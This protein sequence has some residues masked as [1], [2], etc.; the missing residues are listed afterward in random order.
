MVDSGAFDPEKLKNA[1]EN[2]MK[3]AQGVS[4]TSEMEA[5]IQMPTGVSDRGR[6]YL[7]TAPGKSARSNPWG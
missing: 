1:M 7:W 5:A 6:S 2:R 3:K 4:K